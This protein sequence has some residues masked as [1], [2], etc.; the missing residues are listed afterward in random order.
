MSNQFQDPFAIWKTMYDQ[1]EEHWS[2]TLGDTVK[3][4][5]FSAWLGF[6][7]KQMLE[8]QDAVKKS[9]ERYLEQAHLPGK[10]DLANLATLIINLE[11]KVDQ[12]DAK[13]DDLTNL[14]Q[15]IAIPDQR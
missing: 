4:E 14:L 3:T 1:M 12:L 5:S 13:L 9:T 7:Q 2:K 15:T 8:F 6:M 10:Q 11:T